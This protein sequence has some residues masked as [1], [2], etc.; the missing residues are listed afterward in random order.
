[1]SSSLEQA[2]ALYDLQR[3]QDA[4][5]VLSQVIGADP[6]ESQAFTL[7]GAARLALADNQLAESDIRTA[8]RLAPES[9]Q[10]HYLMNY[11]WINR[12]NLWGAERSIKECLR[13]EPTIAAYIQQARILL[14]LNKHTEAIESIRDALSIDARAEEAYIVQAEIQFSLGRAEEAEASIKEALTISP[15]NP[16]AHQLLGIHALLSDRNH[17]AT[18]S[19]TESRRISPI[20]HS[21]AGPLTVAY[22]RSIWPFNL[23]R[24]LSRRYQSLFAI[25]QW[26]LKALV[27]SCLVG[28][29]VTTQASLNQ[30]SPVATIVF[31]A[32]GILAVV[33]YCAESASIMLAIFLR[34][35]KLG[36]R[37]RDHLVLAMKFCA[38]AAVMAAVA[39]GFAFVLTLQPMFALLILLIGI[40][41]RP[42]NA[43]WSI[44]TPLANFAKGIMAILLVIICMAALFWIPTA[45][46]MTL[47]WLTL[48]VASAIVNIP[49]ERSSPAVVA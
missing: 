5:E 33:A 24:L 20:F 45:R 30:F 1:M 21:N 15:N 16:N 41:W 10:A 48:L 22:A 39:T 11:V 26:L 12:N 2:Q 37:R 17:A 6:N 36:V 3:Y 42:L 27:A 44:E 32:V 8:I 43:L 13:I 35:K 4:I 34:P 40:N 46:S 9:A 19:L 47:V 38:A 28:A 49:F 29:L 7:R 18:T 25:G 23:F 31:I 14:A